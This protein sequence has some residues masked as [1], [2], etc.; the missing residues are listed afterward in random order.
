MRESITST[1]THDFSL[2]ISSEFSFRFILF[3]ARS[4][5]HN[6]NFTL[7]RLYLKVLH[8]FVHVSTNLRISS[9]EIC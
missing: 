9:L 8:A 7:L 2:F 3:K 6:D 1:S 4:R 5:F